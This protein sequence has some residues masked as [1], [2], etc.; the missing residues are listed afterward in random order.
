MFNF[1]SVLVMLPEEVIIGAIAGEGGILYYISK[2]IDQK[3]MSHLL[4]RPN[5]SFPL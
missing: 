2:G 3:Q 1:L 4:R 5:S